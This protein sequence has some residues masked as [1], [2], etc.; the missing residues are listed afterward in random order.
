MKE[1]K[2]A[3][4]GT[5][6][7]GN[8]APYGDPSYE[9]WGV[10]R[11]ADYVTR[12]DRWFELHRLDGEP[13]EWAAQWR[14]TLRDFSENIPELWMMYPEPLH[15][16]VVHYPYDRI[17]GRFGT[18]FM[19]STF[20]WMM[21]LAI[22]ELRPEKG[23]P[24]N[25]TISIFGVDMEYGT[26]YRQQRTGF[27]HFVD[28]ARYAGI[29]VERLADGG[30][31]YEPVPYPMWQDDPL[32]QKNNLRRK[33]SLRRLEE[34]DETRNRTKRLYVEDNAIL[35]ELDRMDDDYDIEARAEDLKKEMR[36]LD[37]VLTQTEKDIATLRGQYEEQCW[38]D[39]YL[40]P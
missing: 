17:V 28:L 20:S 26:E 11:R 34:L 24:V 14:E 32:L 40:Q 9:I 33:E 19:T 31:A 3:L 27:R 36:G 29:P 15:K 39:D 2:I 10:S 35:S 22:D 37:S 4:V 6:S 12:A 25:G 1:R 7:S 8:R 30:L 5:A 23:K 21:A 38:L 13:E 18:F 16:N